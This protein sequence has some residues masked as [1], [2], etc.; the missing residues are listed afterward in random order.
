MVSLGGFGRGFRL[1]VVER[2]GFGGLV[3]NLIRILFELINSDFPLSGCLHVIS[4]LM[5]GFPIKS[6]IT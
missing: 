4:L 2:W 6:A 1:E 3:S 5:E